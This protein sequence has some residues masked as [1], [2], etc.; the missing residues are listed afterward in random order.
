MNAGLS[1][2]DTLKRSLLAPAL[3]GDKRYD[4]QLATLGLGVCG[5]F[6][7]FCNRRFGYM[8]NDT[9]EFSGDRPHYYLPRFPMTAV[10][11]IEMRYF[12][13]DDWTEITGQPITISYAEGLVHFGY[14]LGRDPLR[15]RATWSGGYWFNT[16]EPKESDTPAEMP[17]ITD[18]TALRNGAKV[19]TVPPE[20]LSA[21]LFQCEAV[22]SARDKLGVATAEKP[23]VQSKISEVELLPLVKSILGGF[24]RYQLS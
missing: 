7:K 9:V 21:F 23:N 16:I 5:A 18:P 3:I 11:K 14:T 24:V 8:E 6:E 4:F 20:L 2:L 15:V 10:A 1:N 19:E 13:T 12:N 17:Q 22:W